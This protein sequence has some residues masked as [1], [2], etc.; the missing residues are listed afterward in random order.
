LV[1][2]IA[3]EDVAIECKLR[4]DRHHDLPVKEEDEQSSFRSKVNQS[5]S[6]TFIQM[7]NVMQ[8]VV[9]IVLSRNK[10]YWF[11]KSLIPMDIITLV[12]ITPLLLIPKVAD[13]DGGPTP[14]QR[15]LVVTVVVIVLVA[16]VSPIYRGCS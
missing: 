11:W 5:I 1:I 15:I 4:D 10:G 14:D 8:I 6:L 3:D 16:Q 7:F 13:V 12:G 9:K 2:L